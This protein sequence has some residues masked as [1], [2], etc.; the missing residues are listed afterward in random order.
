V[1]IETPARALRRVFI[2]VVIAVLPV[3]CG[4]VSAK[5]A[6]AGGSGGIAGSGG[7]VGSD[8]AAGAGGSAGD[9]GHQANVILHGRI[10]TIGASTSADGGAGNVVLSRRTLMM[11][12]STRACTDGGICITG[13]LTP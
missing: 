12:G 4:S 3:G 10:D 13:R 9:S 11:P 1:T 7:M 5:K 8:A 2:G 6:D